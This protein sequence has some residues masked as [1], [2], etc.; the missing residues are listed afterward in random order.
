MSVGVL[1]GYIPVVPCVRPPF[2]LL[3]NGLKDLG[4]IP[5]PDEL[6]GN[7]I[8]GNQMKYNILRICGILWKVISYDRGTYELHCLISGSSGRW[9]QVQYMTGADLLSCNAQKEN[10]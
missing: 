3:R 7:L 10:D 9:N 8:K 6:I 4:S 5:I 1:T 2:L